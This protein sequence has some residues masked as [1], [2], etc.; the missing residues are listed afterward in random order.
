MITHSHSN[1]EPLAA[2][3]RTLACWSIRNGSPSTSAPGRAAGRGRC[4]RSCLRCRAHPRRGTLE[5]VHRPPPPRL[6]ARRPAELQALLS[7][8]GISPSSTIVFYGYG[9][10]LGFRLDEVLPLRPRAVDGRAARALGAR[11]LPMEHRAAA[12][13]RQ[14]MRAHGWG[15]GPHRITRSRGGADRPT[16]CHDRRRP[17]RGEVRGPALLALGRYRRRRTRRPYSRCG[18]RRAASGPIVRC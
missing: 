16:R 6:H 5:R 18:L 14:L 8:S 9:A 15:P 17:I 12:D 11:R 4:Q 7:S 3:D 2:G 13:N 1:A 10:Y